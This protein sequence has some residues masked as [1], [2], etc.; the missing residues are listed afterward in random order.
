[1][2]TVTWSRPSSDVD[3]VH[4]KVQYQQGSGPPTTIEI[5]GLQRTITIVKGKTYQVR[6]RAVSEI[7]EGPWSSYIT[8]G[9]EFVQYFPC[10]LEMLHTYVRA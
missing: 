4:Y 5:E 3:I 1:M 9:R 10:V 8:V 6:V 2:L 7:A